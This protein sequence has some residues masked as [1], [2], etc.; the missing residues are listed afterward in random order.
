[1][2]KG[3]IG[4]FL[5]MGI[6]LVIVVIFMMSIDPVTENQIISEVDI[7]PIKNFVENCLAESG[8]EGI[9]FLSLQGGYF[10]FERVDETTFEMEIP[11]YWD[12]GVNNMPSKEDIALNLEG[13]MKE[14]L[15]VCLGDFSEFEG[16][17][18]ETGTLKPKVE[19]RE[20]DILVNL[21][22]DI[23]VH[24]ESMQKSIKQT[25]AIIPIDFSY[26]Y[27]TAELIMAE[28]ELVGNVIPLGYLTNLAEER[29]FIYEL[30]YITDNAIVMKINFIDQEFFFVFGLKYPWGE[31][32]I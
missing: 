7:V 18:I 1:M 21:E 24:G 31:D 4:L 29:N 32:G 13:Y 5:L 12:D 27:L 8:T 15:P 16:L 10:I 23:V 30:E 2:K 28:Q 19:F 25:S 14:V 20:G 6:I 22:N 26:V 17:E 11:F 3:Q 9:R